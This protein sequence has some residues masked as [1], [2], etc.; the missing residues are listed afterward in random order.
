[1]IHAERKNGAE[2]IHAKSGIKKGAGYTKRETATRE[3]YLGR[4]GGFMKKHYAVIHSGG[5]RL[6]EINAFLRISY[7]F[8]LTISVSIPSYYNIPILIIFILTSSARRTSV[9]VIY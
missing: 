8:F 2:I 3:D 9:L 5:N 7:I 6:I 4:S 1:M